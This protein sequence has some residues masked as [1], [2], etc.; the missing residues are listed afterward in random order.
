MWIAW[1]SCLLGAQVYEPL[2]SS[3]NPGSGVPPA[4]LQIRLS[5]MWWE[6]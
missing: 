2:S 1:E 5:E 3:A 4:E 6:V